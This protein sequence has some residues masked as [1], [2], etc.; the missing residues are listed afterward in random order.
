VK[1]P[2]GG[3]L[4]FMVHS[5]SER[6]GQYMGSLGLL[7]GDMD[8][9]CLILE[10]CDA[11]GTDRILGSSITYR[12]ALSLHQACEAF[13]LQTRAPAGSLEESSAQVTKALGFLLH[14]DWHFSQILVF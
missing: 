6:V 4:E 13:T 11:S 14:D 3:E 12:I 2:F 10:P 9:S 1:T 8:N 7:V 5:L